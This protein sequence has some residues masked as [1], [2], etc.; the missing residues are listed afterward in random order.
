MKAAELIDD[1]ELVS[2]VPKVFSPDGD[3]FDDHCAVS[4]EFEDA[5]RT[6]NVYVFNADGQLIRHLVRGELIGNEGSFIWNGLDQKGRRVPFGIYVFVTEVF[7]MEGKVLR[8]KNA[9]TVA[10]R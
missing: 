4:Y 6:M 8:Y 5:G 2:V 7:D 9:V 1:E 3:G 10:S